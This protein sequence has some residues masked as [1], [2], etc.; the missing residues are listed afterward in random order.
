MFD[1]L[2]DLGVYEFFKVSFWKP[3]SKVASAGRKVFIQG[4]RAGM[5]SKSPAQKA[6]AEKLKQQGRKM[7]GRAARGQ[8]EGAD[9]ECKA[10]GKKIRSKGRGRGLGTGKGKGPIGRLRISVKEERDKA[11]GKHYKKKKAAFKSA[12]SRLMEGSDAHSMNPNPERDDDGW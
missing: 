8:S 4:I 6:M 3:A 7:L 9:Y 11:H 12:A 10:P 2:D 5:K 1:G